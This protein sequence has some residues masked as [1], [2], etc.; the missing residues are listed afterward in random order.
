[1]PEM[2]RQA[3]QR[4][5]RGADLSAPIPSEDELLQVVLQVRL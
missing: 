3:K 2:Y 5:E 4:I 1:M